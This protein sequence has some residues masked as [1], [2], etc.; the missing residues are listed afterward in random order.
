M[1]I[2]TPYE[3]A[4]DMFVGMNITHFFNI[5][6]NTTEHMIS[7]IFDGI[8]VIF[9]L[10]GL[11]FGVMFIFA[12]FAIWNEFVNPPKKRN[13][14]IIDSNQQVEQP[15]PTFEEKYHHKFEHIIRF[16]NMLD[17]N[18]A[19]DKFFKI[20]NRTT[21]PINLD[22]GDTTEN[23]FAKLTQLIKVN[24][25]DTFADVFHIIMTDKAFKMEDNMTQFYYL[26]YSDYL[27]D[28]FQAFR[29]MIIN[30][31]CS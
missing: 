3:N 10:F 28:E 17:Y 20:F 30:I 24:N 13:V 14:T 4:S 31:D 5:L 29:N 6:N 27:E 18:C 23:D 12:P 11:T 2:F 19:E 22:F 15:E 16:M 26:L 9:Y 7:G 21:I 25:I 1:E 8:Y